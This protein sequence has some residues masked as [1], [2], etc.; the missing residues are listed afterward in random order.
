[1]LIKIEYMFNMLQILK[2][3]LNRYLMDHVEIM[4]IEFNRLCML[5]ENKN[6]TNEVM[7]DNLQNKFL[8]MIY[9]WFLSW[10]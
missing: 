3:K 4:S 10:T 7:V 5:W 6:I 8:Y 9:K 1:M 2:V